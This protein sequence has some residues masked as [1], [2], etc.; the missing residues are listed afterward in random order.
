MKESFRYLLIS[1]FLFFL[2]SHSVFACGEGVILTVTSAA[3]ASS[4]WAVIYY[5]TEVRDDSGFHSMVSNP[6]RITIPS[7]YDGWYLLRFHV[8][9]SDSFP[10]ASYGGLC[11]SLNGTCMVYEMTDFDVCSYHYSSVSFLYY[12]SAGDYLQSYMFQ[13]SGSTKTYLY[14]RFSA[15]HIGGFDVPNHAATHENGGGDEINI[16]GLSGLLADPQD[17][18]WLQ[19]LAISTTDPTDGQ[20]LIWN[21]S[22]SQWE[23][24]DLEE[25]SLPDFI[26]ATIS[27]TIPVVITSTYHYTAELNSGHDIAVI[28]SF[29]Y[30]EMGIALG[31]F[32]LLALFSLKWLFELVK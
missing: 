5:D 32:C 23:P 26:T 3:I 8:R 12:L 30:G 14:L 31:L 4:S 15:V 7:G 21:D 28:R 10:P 9:S 18:G 22:G 25:A 2:F 16:A 29:T 19:D 6:D 27:G 24:D 17:A 11:I 20:I 1:L 13:N